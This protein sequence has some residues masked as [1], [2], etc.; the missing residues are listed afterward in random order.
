MSKPTQSLIWFKQRNNKKNQKCCGNESN[1]KRNTADKRPSP[2]AQQLDTLASA[3]NASAYSTA[4]PS[5]AKSRTPRRSNCDPRTQATSVA[6]KSQWTNGVAHAHTVLPIKVTVRVHY[7]S[8]IGSQKARTRVIASRI[9]LILTSRTGKVMTSFLES[10]CRCRNRWISLRSWIYIFS[11]VLKI[12]SWEI[13]SNWKRI[14]RPRL[15]KSVTV[16]W[17]SF[18]TMRMNRR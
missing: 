16:C 15:H 11:P 4:H 2:E 13:H 7:P 6:N 5:E 3:R 1:S 8:S 10:C 17:N 18:N 14:I 12:H 9:N